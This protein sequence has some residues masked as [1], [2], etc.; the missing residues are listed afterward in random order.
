MT[1]LEKIKRI[2]E[3]SMPPW[4]DDDPYY[5]REPWQKFGGISSGIC[6][7]WFWYRDEIIDAKTTDDDVEIA[8]EEVVRCHQ[9]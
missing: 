7:C 5:F 1:K 9:R 4:D 2:K 6:M 3:L 8:Y